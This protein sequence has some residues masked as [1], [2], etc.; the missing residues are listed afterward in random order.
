M[1]KKP[2]LDFKA[3]RE[4]TPFTAVLDRYGVRLNR[5]NATTLKGN[6]PLPSHTSKTRDTFYVNEEKNV[7]YCHSDSCKKSGSRGGNVIDF[8]AAMEGLSAY[9]SAAKLNEWFGAYELRPPKTS[10]PPAVAGQS[11]SV[12]SAGNKPLGF[13]LKDVNPEHESIQARGITI[14]TARAWG[15]GFYCSKQKTASMDHRIVFPLYENGN[16]VGYAGRATLEGQEP[17]WLLGKGLVKS[18]LYGLDRCD[19]AKPLI[20]AESPWAV[21]WFHQNGAQAAALLGSEMTQAQEESLSPFG[22]I[23]VALDN[24]P[25]GNEKAAPIL[26]RLKRNHKVM[27]ARLME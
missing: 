1:E 8:V 5:G 3:I 24:D 9:D 20:L 26:E 15:V 13:A 22:V 19:P 14:E 16:L 2:Y 21:L 18:F 4:R 27:K 17:K 10:A 7:W 12:S 6:C 11:D 23:T 25:A